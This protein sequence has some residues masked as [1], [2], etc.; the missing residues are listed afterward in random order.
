MIKKKN[1]RSKKIKS[2]KSNENITRSAMHSCTQR[3]GFTVNIICPGSEPKSYSFLLLYIIYNRCSYSLTITESMWV[4][5][6]M[7]RWMNF[8]ILKKSFHSL[9]AEEHSFIII[10]KLLN[11]SLLAASQRWPGRRR[12]RRTWELQKWKTTFSFRV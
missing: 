7:G 3:L 11:L 1:K 4:L 10:V 8:E 5:S 9:L 2:Y 6:W 12:R